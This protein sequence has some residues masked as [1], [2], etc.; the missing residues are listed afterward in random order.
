MIKAKNVAI[1]AVLGFVLSFLLS[2]IAT[3]SFAFSLL[4][5]LIFAVVFAGLAMGI[6]FLYKKFLSDD[7]G[8]DFSSPERKKSGSM[9]DIT[10]NDETLPDDGQG[11]QFFVSNNKHNLTEEDKISLNE[12]SN[13]KNQDSSN[14]FTEK[15]NGASTVVDQNEEAEGFKPVPLGQP[16]AAENKDSASTVSEKDDSEERLDTLPD[17]GN[18]V[19]DEKKE[20]NDNGLIKDSDFA[21]FGQNES[22]NPAEF[23]DGS[24]AVNHDTETMAKAIRTLLKKDE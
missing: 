8:N 13:D 15:S 14:D 2:L 21:E 4:R 20:T 6:M 1:P 10:I 7:G 5:G 16:F 24:K 11:P 22:S 3:H 17:I 12:G 19:S 23:P 18:I 9:V